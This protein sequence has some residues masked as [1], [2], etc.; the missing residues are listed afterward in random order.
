MTAKRAAG[1]VIGMLLAG[2]PAAQQAPPSIPGNVEQTLTNS[3]LLMGRGDYA[4]ALALLQPLTVGTGPG[5][6]AA[7]AP[8][9]RANLYFQ[10]SAARSQTGADD[11]ALEDADRAER[12]ARAVNAYDLLARIESVRGI[13]WLSRGRS[14]ESLQHLRA[15][16]DWAQ[17]SNKAPLIAGAYIR[18]AAAYQ[19]AGDWPRALDAVNRS[20]EAD[21]SPSEGARVQYLARR[22]LVEIELHDGAA[23][24][25]SIGE[26]LALTRKIGDRRN[27][28]QVLIDLALVSQRADRRSAESAEYAEQAAAIA[29][30]IQSPTIEIPALNQWASALLEAGDP[31]AARDRLQDALAV[32]ADV[33]EHR[34]EPYVLSNLG[35]AQAL[36]GQPDE[37]ERTLRVAA[38]RADADGLTRVRWVARL[39]LAGL[40]AKHDPDA[41]TAQFEDGLAVLEERQT[42]V[43]LEGFRAGALDPSR[44]DSDPYDRYVTFLMDRG[45][46]AGA[47]YAAERE[48][49]RVFLDALSGA[50]DAIAAAVPADFKEAENAALRKI[51]TAQAELRSSPPAARRAALLA[52]IEA[53]E[54]QLRTLRVRL[55]ADR[56]ALAH[57]RYPTLSPAADLQS[58]VLAPDEALVSYFL[59]TARSVCWILTRDR[60]TAVTLPPRDEIER[61]IRAA[62]EELRDPSV[63]A[64]KSLAP[65][66]HALGIDAVSG[67]AGGLHLIVVPHG[68]LYDVPFEVLPGA[69]GR[70]LIERFPISYAPSASTLAFFR[71]LPPPEKSA[72]TLVAIGDPVVRGGGASTTRQAD[73]SHVDLLSPLPN[74]RSEIRG[75]A[76]L[77]GSHV[78]VLEAAHATEAELFAGGADQ[79]VMLHFA[80]HGL[81]DE[82]RPERSGLVL[83]AN[84]PRDDGLLQTREIYGLTLHASLVT[85]SGCQTALG[86]NVTGEGMIGLTRAFFYAGARAIVASLWDVEDEATS[87]LMQQFYRNIRDGEPIDVALQH[88]KL[89]FIKAGGHAARPFVWASFVVSGQARAKVD[90]PPPTPLQRFAASFA[91][92]AG[93]AAI[94]GLIIA[95][96]FAR[97]LISSRGAALRAASPK[98]PAAP[99]L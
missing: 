68:I 56:P 16:L 52:A 89:S 9:Q 46:S 10:L 34:D 38:A 35:R 67:L 5:E 88:A 12:D 47:F 31:A 81:I 14:V 79:A 61:S 62:L 3:Q 48:R 78:R 29:R 8:A 80:T 82:M 54:T 73:L 90:V 39:Q 98:T 57:A 36:L 30:E 33:E 55:A 72:T 91:A 71:T 27:E 2:S 25:Q 65:L 83:T 51:S 22:G 53:D 95:L 93:A 7:L 74:S 32:I 58:R 26:A 1:V 99:T 41:A 43:L 66:T 86:Q 13:V 42:N 37:A 11:L 85:L 17:Q 97:R 4:G 21:P 20:A 96:L 63:T 64:P 70:P 94:A 45:D 44:A 50:R 18:L 28:A 87:R 23:A 40:L 75:I 15:C 49:A 92:Q 6:A 69:D 84:P 59:G 77:F 19:D 60:M 76:S 24:K